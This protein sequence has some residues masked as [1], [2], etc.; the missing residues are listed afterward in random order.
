[1]KLLRLF[2]L[3]V[4]VFTLLQADVPLKLLM[5]RVAKHCPGCRL[6]GVELK[7]INLDGANLRNA[8]L[9]WATFSSVNLNNADL[10]GANLRHARLNEVS[11]QNTNFCHATLMDAAK[12]YCY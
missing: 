8:D 9:R 6:V 2:A 11:T 10:S 12:G 4:V 5:L 1:M 7:D 3:T